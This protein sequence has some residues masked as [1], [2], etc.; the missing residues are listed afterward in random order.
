MIVVPDGPSRRV[1]PNGLV[2]GRQHDSDIILADPSASRRHALIRLTADGAEVVPIGRSPIEVNGKSHDRPCALADGDQLAMPGLVLVVE[3]RAQRP[4]PRGSAAYRLERARGGSFGIVHTP[5]VIGS[6]EGDDLIVKGWPAHALKLHVAQGE[7]YVEVL[8]GKATRNGGELE[9]GALEP[10]AIDDELGYRREAFVV[11]SAVRDATTAVGGIGLP[12]HVTIEILPRGGRMVFAVAGSEHA[13]YLADRRFD[14]LVALLRPPEGYVAG[15]FIPDDV[16]R[17]IV[18][19]RNPGVSRPE[20]NSLISRC[21]R[22]LV[23]AGLAGARLL[24][25]APGGGATK[26]ALAV[27]ATVMM[28]G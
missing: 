1:G 27:G 15:D 14:L 3:V 12:T 16:V 24:V 25:R 7:L 28:A 4:D 11:R 5:F 21:R 20:I 9:P 18:W 8:A 2:V 22:D 19:P 13:V 26:L 23:E 17:T 10:L 6:D